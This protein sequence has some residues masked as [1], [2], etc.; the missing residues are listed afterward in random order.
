MPQPIQK[1]DPLAAANFVADKLGLPEPSELLEELDLKEF[2]R[3]HGIP[4]PDELS[5]RAIGEFQK[6][7]R[8]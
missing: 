6:F 7:K 3:D 8:R 4:T 5:D 1:M 2:A